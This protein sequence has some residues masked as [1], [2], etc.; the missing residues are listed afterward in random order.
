M[1][2][3]ERGVLGRAARRSG[4]GRPRLLGAVA[5][6]VAAGLEQLGVGDAGRGG[7]E[8]D[9]EDGGEGDEEPR[10]AQDGADDDQ[11]REHEE[12]ARDGQPRAALL[13]P[14]VWR[15]VLMGKP[16]SRLGLVLVGYGRDTLA[17]AAAP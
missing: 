14:A 4:R 11:R 13:P 2:V 9:A 6:G 10:A 5:G 15:V 7:A 12:G 17:P 16:Y 8:D 1:V 3:G